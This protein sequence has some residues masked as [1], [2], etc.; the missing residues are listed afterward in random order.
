MRQYAPYDALPVTML[1]RMNDESACAMW[2]QKCSG[3]CQATF[4]LQDLGAT[5]N[6]HKTAVLQISQLNDSVSTYLNALRAKAKSKATK[7]ADKV[8]HFKLAEQF[9]QQVSLIAGSTYS[10]GTRYCCSA[11]RCNNSI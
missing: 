8:A 9:V 6:C 10:Y 4:G 5:S 1:T 2:V 11:A 3:Q 7:P